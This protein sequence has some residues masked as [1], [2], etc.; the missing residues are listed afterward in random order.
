MCTANYADQVPDFVQDRAEFINIELYTYQQRLEYVMG[1]LR[2]KLGK[3]NRTSYAAGQLTEEFCKYLICE[4]WG[5]RQTNANMEN[6]YKVLR[7][8]AKLGRRIENFTQ[9]ERVEETDNRFIFHYEGG[10]KLTLTRLRTEN[11]E[12]ESVLSEVL[13]LG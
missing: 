7:G 1:M 8:Y 11:L 13:R 6:V 2:R 12:G 3:N 5:L 10:Q 9:F 4:A